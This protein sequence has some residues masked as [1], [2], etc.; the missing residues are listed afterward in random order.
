MFSKKFDLDTIT[1][2]H[3]L[4][5]DG[6]KQMQDYLCSTLPKG[7]SWGFQGETV[8]TEKSAD[9]DGEKLRSIVDGFIGPLTTH[10][11]Y[12]HNP[13]VSTFPDERNDVRVQLQA[14][15]EYLDPQKLRDAGLTVKDILETEVVVEKVNVHVR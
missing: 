3:G 2:E 12:A 7:T 9:Y 14:E 5:S 1:A 13:L 6:M 10:V 8:Q 4:F 15:I 11:R